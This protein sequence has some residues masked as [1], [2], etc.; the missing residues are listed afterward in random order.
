MH[1]TIRLQPPEDTPVARADALLALS[2]VLGGA[3]HDL[4]PLRSTGDAPSLSRAPTRQC[5]SGRPGEREL[6]TSSWWHSTGRFVGD[7]A[8]DPVSRGLVT[9]IVDVSRLLGLQTVAEGV[10]VELRQGWLHGRPAPA[11]HG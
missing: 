9:A 7:L 6:R 5:S 3:T 10:G 2:D 8:H 1:P 4:D 11:V